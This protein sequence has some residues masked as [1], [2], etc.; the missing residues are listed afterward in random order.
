MRLKKNAN[1]SEQNVARS[2]KEIFTNNFQSGYPNNIR[3]EIR[4]SL[5][6]LENEL[7][8]FKIT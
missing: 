3:T 5:R 4:N 2:L 8:Y 7:S 1:N 6:L